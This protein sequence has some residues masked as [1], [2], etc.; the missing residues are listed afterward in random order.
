MTLSQIKKRLEEA[1]IENAA[2][3]ARMLSERFSPAELPEKVALRAS[4][5]PLQYIFV[6]T[7]SHPLI[8]NYIA[9]ACT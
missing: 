9:D 1:G 8:I 3:E 7:S 2:G 5:Y 4:L 6:V